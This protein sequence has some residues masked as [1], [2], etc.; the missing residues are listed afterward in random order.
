MK[1]KRLLY[2]VPV[3]GVHEG[4][5]G[6][7]EAQIDALKSVASVKKIKLSNKKPLFLNL[8][9]FV[10]CYEV[11]AVFF[12]IFSHAIYARYNPKALISTFFLII[13]SFFKPVFLEHNIKLQDELSF[14]GRAIEKKMDRLFLFL[15]RVSYIQH[16]CL[17]EGIYNYLKHYNISED[18]LILSQNGCSMKEANTAQ[19]SSEL[20]EFKQ[21]YEKLA[22]FVGNP[23]A[24]NGLSE[25]HQL[26]Q[27]LSVGLCIVGVGK[28]EETLSDTLYLGRL[29]HEEMQSVFSVCDFGVGAFDYQKLNMND[30]SSLK[31]RDYLSSG[32]PVVLKTPDMALKNPL[33]RPYFF[34]LGT[35]SDL[36]QFISKEVDK[37]S[38]VNL[39]KEQLS[40]SVT[41]KSVLDRIRM[42]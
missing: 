22:V 11:K 20:S 23:H 6:K 27:G 26:F 9:F 19:I 38:L 35:D 21:K 13:I 41:L 39:A 32:L 36:K 34:L 30:S 40:W 18:C 33:L 31:V 7:I 2:L 25:I 5:N 8:P 16:V 12:S 17:S 4:I 37:N 28:P 14:L 10:L 42:I 29:G 3:Y 15:F 1:T 24:W